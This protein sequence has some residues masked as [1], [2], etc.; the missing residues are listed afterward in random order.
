MSSV[1]PID[2]QRYE[3]GDY[4]LE[5]TAHPSPL[6][7]WSDRPVVR[8]LRFNL[9]VERPERQR[10]ATGDQRQLTTLSHTVETYVHE[11]LTQSAWPNIHRIQL[12]GKN[13]ELRTLELFHLAEVLNAH[14]LQQIV[15]PAAPAKRRPKRHWWTGSAAA[16]LLVAVGV[17]TAYIQ[18]RPQ[19]FDQAET[20]QAPTIADEA[21]SGLNDSAPADRA[22]PEAESR[23]AKLPG[24]PQFSEAEGTP[25][26]NERPGDLEQQINPEPPGD[27]GRSSVPAASP[28]DAVV[29]SV[30]EVD[31]SG[32]GSTDAAE[33]PIATPP[34]P[35]QSP[36]LERSSSAEPSPAAAVAT[37]GEETL[38]ADDLANADGAELADSAE[39]NEESAAIARNSRSQSAPGVT[40]VS[41]HGSGNGA[42]GTPPVALPNPI[43]NRPIDG[44]I[45][46][47]IARQLGRYQPMGV[48][49]P[50]VYHVQI[51]ADGTIHSIEPISEGAPAIA[52]PE[53]IA[54]P[55][56]PVR[57]ELIYTGDNLPTLNE[58]PL[59]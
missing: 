26:E 35:Q 52:P 32:V 58:L 40:G 42:P 38:A 21:G 27:I 10:L 31:T 1:L 36:A 53:K 4:T 41:G 33:P 14:G 6:S 20:V 19:A 5:V 22:T 49:Y 16:S 7:Q 24:E 12:L 15:L 46:N 23:V 29:N 25:S 11:N 18:Y 43:D 45:I 59:E 34:Q 37:P 2:T 47:R 3:S 13:I 39:L 30:P 44:A 51:F 57:L 17:A 56:R 28:S 54:A 48:A 55:G 9:W 50:L 8:R